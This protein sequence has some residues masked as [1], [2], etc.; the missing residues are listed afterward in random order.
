[1]LITSSARWGRHFGVEDSPLEAFLRDA[2]CGH[3][4]TQTVWL[5]ASRGFDGS[6]LEEV[7]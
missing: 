7:G 6:S 3:R 1:M 2:G 4:V 5:E